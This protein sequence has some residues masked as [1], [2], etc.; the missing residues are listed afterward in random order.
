LLACRAD[1]LRHA[2]FA[3]KLFREYR[4]RAIRNSLALCSASICDKAAKAHFSYITKAMPIFRFFLQ[5]TTQDRRTSCSSMKISNSSGTGSWESGSICAPPADTSQIRH[6]ISGE[7]LSIWIAPSLQVLLRRDL[8][9]SGARTWRSATDYTDHAAVS[10]RTPSSSSDRQ[11]TRQACRSSL[12][13]IV[14]SNRS[15]MPMTLLTRMSAPSAVTFLTAQ[16]KTEDWLRIIWAVFSTCLRG[17]ERRSIIGQ[18]PSYWCEQSS[19][20]QIKKRLPRTLYF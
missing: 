18:Q 12:G 2:W 1:R 8:R 16:S 19:L 10:K 14:R 17:S 11:I 6:S 20:L 15:G 9:R 13:S 7:Q 4:F 5:I 3:S